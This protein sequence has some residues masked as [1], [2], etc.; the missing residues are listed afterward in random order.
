M[1]IIIEVINISKSVPQN[2]FFI[3]G[4]IKFCPF[5]FI[6]KEELLRL[7]PFDFELPLRPNI[8]KGEPP[9]KTADRLIFK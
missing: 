2:T 4:G 5:S 7:R 6:L 3:L 9:S 8:K 1:E